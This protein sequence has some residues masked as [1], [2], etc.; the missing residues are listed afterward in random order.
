M[1]RYARRSCR[2]SE[3][4]SWIA[5]ALEGRAGARLA[6]K[7]GFFVSRTALFYELR[8][9]SHPPARSSSRVLGI[10]EWAWKKG[11]RYGTILCDL[12]QGLVIDLLPTRDSETVA[13]WLR[14]HPSVQVVS[15]DRG[16]SLAL[17]EQPCRVDTLLRSLERHRGMVRAVRVLRKVVPTCRNCGV[18]SGSRISGK[19]IERMALAAAPLRTLA[20]IRSDTTREEKSTSMPRAR[21]LADAEGPSPK[22]SLSEGPVRDVPRTESARPYSERLLRDDP[23]PRCRSVASLARRSCALEAVMKLF[24]VC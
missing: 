10:D 12:E 21:R 3:A 22:T 15:R 18:S 4:L 6:C 9:R 20:N 2:S 19:C 23:Q 11:H 7:L 14:E 1:R 17:A 8:R 5:L 24:V 16:G 13:A